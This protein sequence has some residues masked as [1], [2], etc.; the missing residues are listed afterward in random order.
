MVEL[1]HFSLEHETFDSAALKDNPAGDPSQRAV[2]VLLPKSRREHP[3]RRYP[4]LYFLAGYAGSGHGFL[5]W[6]SWTPSLP[7]RLDRLRDTDRI[8]DVIAVFP[9]A[10]TVY[11]GSQYLNS[12]ATGQYEEMLV[13]DLVGW[14]DARYPALLDAR[15]RALLGKSSGGYAALVLGMRHADVFSAVACHSGD[16]YFEYCYAHDFPRLLRQLDKYGSLDAFMEAFF[17]APKKTSDLVLSMNIVAMAAAYSPNPDL[18]WRVE[19]PFDA[20]TG[21][22]R[23]DVWKRWL[24]QDPVRLCEEHASALKQLRLLYL[25]CGSRDQFHLQYGLRILRKRL[26]ALGIAYEAE[27]FNDDHSD[28]SYR[29]D[30]SIPRV[31]QSV[32]PSVTEGAS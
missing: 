9:D 32:K 24:A 26:D 1:Q 28:T 11:G 22:I 4:V 15:H 5:N 10:F 14:I 2:P 18:P 12:P 27:E 7:E 20:R 17:T 23:V 29:Y 3:E 31:W 6:K 21:E 30:E 25:E 8:G 19:L 16:M 13:N